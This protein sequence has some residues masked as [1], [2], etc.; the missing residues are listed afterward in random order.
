M[1][2][3]TNSLASLTVIVDRNRLQQGRSTEEVNRLEPLADKWRAFGWAVD[4]VDGHDPSAIQAALLPIDGP[5]GK[6]RCLIAHTSKGKGVSF[7]QDNAA[8]HHRLPTAA[9]ALVALTELHTGVC[10]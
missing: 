3:A 4:E 5:W 7:M 1:L 10:A 6:P 2:A 8:W 9:E